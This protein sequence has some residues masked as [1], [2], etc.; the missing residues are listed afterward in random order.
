MEAS[1][2]VRPC[3]SPLPSEAMA[4]VFVVKFSVRYDQDRECCIRSMRVEGTEN[5]PIVVASS[6]LWRAVFGTV[7]G[8]AIESRWPTFQLFL[9]TVRVEM[10]SLILRFSG[11]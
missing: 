7:A 4:A 9:G 10:C 11:L 8:K 3:R 2:N 6:F 5:R 1:K